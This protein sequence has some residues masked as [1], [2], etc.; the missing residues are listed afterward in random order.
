MRAQKK[1]ED[2]CL[3]I[4]GN[5]LAYRCKFV[6]ALSYNGIDT[7][8]TYGFLKSLVTLYDKFH[9]SSIVVCW[10]GGIPE[11]RRVAVP[12]YKAGRHVDE[13]PLA[14]EDFY[15]QMNELHKMFSYMNIL[16]IRGHGIEADDLMYHFTRMAIDKTIIVTGDKDLYQ[17]INAKTKVYNPGK[18][19]LYDENAVMDEFGISVEQLVDWRALQGD[20]SDNIPGVSG[21]GEKTS[22]KLFKEWGSLTAII[23]AALGHDPGKMVHQL[24]PALSAKICAFGMERIF[25]NIYVMA[26]YADRV[27]ARKVILDAYDEERLPYSRTFITRYLLKNAFATLLDKLPGYC[28]KLQLPLVSTADIRIPIVGM[29]RVAI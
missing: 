13:D 15:R 6:Y 12:E 7:S 17:A 2:L 11:F 5:H 23:N 3:V 22:T 26:L 16:S 27:G 28:G 19:K 8:V 18:E 25:K 29:K 9:P 10:D 1:I 4:D 20:G 24:S 21:I 14:R